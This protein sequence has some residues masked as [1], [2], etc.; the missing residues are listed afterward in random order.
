MLNLAQFVLGGPARA[1]LVAA[2]SGLLA[3]L[4]PPLSP[5]AIVLSG[6]V[7]VLVAQRHPPAVTLMVAGWS[8]LAVTA[9]LWPLGLPVLSLIPL[10]VWLGMVACGEVL[11]RTGH[12]ALA[13]LTV[14]A[15]VTGAVLMLF[16]WV[17]QPSQFW[18]EALGRLIEA[19][20]SAGQ[21]P[22]LDEAQRE[23][24]ARLLTGGVATSVQVCMIAS[25]LLARWWQSRLFDGP[26]FRHEFH[27]LRMG[28]VL[29]VYAVALIAAAVI[30]DTELLIALSA[31]AVSLYLFQGLA[32]V[33]A[34]SAGYGGKRGWLVAFYVL[35]VLLQPLRSMVVV[36]GM[37]D[38]WIDSRRRWLTRPPAG[39]GNENE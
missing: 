6:A 17:P 5:L 39:G 31:V 21:E 37:V 4:V 3:V 26:V 33:H 15:L 20:Q 25:L 22:L 1:V 12:L 32:V 34:F 36:L 2:A 14:T 8:Q 11:R 7:L 28:R 18:F 9:V 30:V 16:V 24:M 10:G 23:Q 35:L 38:A 19:G 27:S 29:T 13:M